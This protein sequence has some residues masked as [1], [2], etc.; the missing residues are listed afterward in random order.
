MSFSSLEVTER[1]LTSWGNALDTFV[2][3]LRNPADHFLEEASDSVSRLIFLHRNRRGKLKVVWLWAFEF[4]LSHS[5]R[6]CRTRFAF[7][8]L[9]SHGHFQSESW[10]LHFAAWSWL[11]PQFH[12]VFIRG[13]LNRGNSTVE[14]SIQ[15]GHRMAHLRLEDAE[16]TTEQA[17]HWRAGW[18]EGLASVK[19]LGIWVYLHTH[20]F[21]YIYIYTWRVYIYIYIYIYLKQW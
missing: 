3:S 5:E 8:V 2:V 17:C 14:M 15:I 21:M 18:G 6:L 20:V 13:V 10:E 12:H 19:S 16:A 11:F 4:L 1:A 7:S 9:C